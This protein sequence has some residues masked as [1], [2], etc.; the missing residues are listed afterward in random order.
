M[1]PRL[2]GGH[3][4]EVAEPADCESGTPYPLCNTAEQAGTCQGHVEVDDVAAVDSRDSYG[5]MDYTR[6]N[7][8]GTV[9]V[10]GTPSATAST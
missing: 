2:S 9:F 1:D 10:P 7:A 4:M 3:T 8:A 5:T 6:N